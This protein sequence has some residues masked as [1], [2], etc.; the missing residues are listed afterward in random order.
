MNLLEKKEQL[1]LILKQTDLINTMNGGVVDTAVNIIRSESRIV[2]NVSAPSVSGKAFKVLL[3]QDQLTVFSL[4]TVE[5]FPYTRGEFTSVPMFIK[6][7]EIPANIDLD[8]IQAEQNDDELNVT[9][10]LKDG[11]RSQRIFDIREL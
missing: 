7:F 5:D 4:L 9:L 10:P 6:T 3:N 11:N 8:N 2:I 1:R